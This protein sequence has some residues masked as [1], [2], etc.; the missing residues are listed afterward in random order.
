MAEGYIDL[1]PIIRA[2]NVVNDNL[3]TVNSNIRIL[4]D[5]QHS[6]AATQDAM[7][8]KQLD[9]DAVLRLLRAEFDDFVAQDRKA[10]SLHLAE[11]RVGNL[12]QELQIK[13]GYY[14]EIRR[15]AT[16]I[17]QA[18]DTGIVGNE[19]IQSTTEE[20]MIK[21]PGYW[22]APALV[23][24]A[25]WIR[26]DKPTCDKALAECLKR[27]DYKATL[28]F[29]LLTRRLARNEASLNWLERYFLHQDPQ[30]L[31]REF[32]T[33]LEGVTTGV[34]PPASRTVMMKHV[35]SWLDQLTQG[36]RFINE[37]KTQWIKYFEGSKPALQGEKYPLLKQFAKNWPMLENSL[38]D[39]KVQEILHNHFSG[40]ISSSYDFSSSVKVK[41]D[42]ILTQLVTNFDDEELPLQKQ[43][44]LNQL[45]I[46][47]DGDKDAAQA[48]MDAEENIFK[49]KVDFLQMLTNAAFN[50]EA[51]GVTKVTQALAVSISQPWIIEAHD[52][53]TAQCRS[54]VPQTVELVIDGFAT[55][56]KNGSDE[57]DQL[58]K[59]ENYYDTELERALG[60]VT[61]PIANV[62]IGAIIAL[63]GL[64]LA[65]NGTLIGLLGTLIGGIMIWNS[66]NG[67]E[68]KKSE[69]RERIEE[70]KKK[71]KEVLR[72]CLAE[73]VDY[74]K[75]LATEDSKAENVRHLLSSITPQDFSSVSLETARNII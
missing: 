51:A 36:D 40:I 62:A 39:A 65:I 52:T 63:G 74:R 45:I 55:A 26:D 31:D 73:T 24:L 27:D 34:F 8:R 66:I 25:S 50:P 47:K 59:Q 13:Y 7:A 20:V 35:K 17:L 11:T 67:I 56:T 15:M 22:L 28:F 57:N 10:K 48:V 44:R 23:S 33:V 4:S 19:T 6:M 30:N 1:S 61:F 9:M 42:E 2:I 70:R 14:A 37:Q 32:I 3:G 21:A 16:G 60:E 58:A 68:K 12:R 29:M 38:C 54:K 18:A 5:V 69:V 64:L 49:E 75:E 43:V 46:E 72:G 53:F 41:L 71:A